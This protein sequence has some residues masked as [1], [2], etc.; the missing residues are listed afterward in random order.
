MI[1]VA[2]LTA[3]VSF[4]FFS[5]SAAQPARDLTPGQLCSSPKTLDHLFDIIART[6]EMAR[7]EG[8]DVP[9]AAAAKTVDAIK[10][11][12]QAEMITVSAVDATIRKT[13]CGAILN[14]AVPK[15]WQPAIDWKEAVPNGRTTDGIQVRIAY[16]IQRSAD[17][18]QDI[19]TLEDPESVV[20]VVYQ[21][22]IFGVLRSRG[23]KPNEDGDRN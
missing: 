8:V 10:R 12:A 3:V 6:T 15:D 4:G 5:P 11:V 1:R 14:L 17:G 21:A 23:V 9:T 7:V 22:S 13:S 19:I 2:G 16:S 18:K 20:A